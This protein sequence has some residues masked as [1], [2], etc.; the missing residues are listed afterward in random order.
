MNIE[1][2]RKIAVGLT[3]LGGIIFWV[4]AAGFVLVKGVSLLTVW[5]AGV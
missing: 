3:F 5:I 4:V 2:E 1:K